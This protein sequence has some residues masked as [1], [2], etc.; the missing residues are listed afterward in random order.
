MEGC[1]LEKV[2]TFFYSPKMNSTDGPSNKKDETVI[3]TAAALVEASGIQVTVNG[4]RSKLIITY[5]ATM[6]SVSGD[7]DE[8]ADSSASDLNNSSDLDSLEVGCIKDADVLL[9]LENG[10]SLFAHSKC[11]KSNPYFA[12]HFN[13]LETNAS[14][15]CVR[16]VRALPP[17]PSAFRTIIELIY[18]F[19]GK[20]PDESKAIAFDSLSVKQVCSSL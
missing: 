20:H 8:N 19:C 16:A 17:F 13:F 1:R 5:E 10:E 14:S 3:G 7:E 11:L 4:V 6:K 12:S 9:V 2:F 15:C 18:N